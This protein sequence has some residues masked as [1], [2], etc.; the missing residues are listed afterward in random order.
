[1]T[2][3]VE[4]TSSKLP[5]VEEKRRAGTLDWGKAK[6][7]AKEEEKKDKKP[8]KTM[9]NLKVCLLLF[10]G[11]NKRKLICVLLPRPQYPAH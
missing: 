10:H 8:M 3:V 1:M 11:D 4:G 5:R 7:K 6:A 9:D 2:K